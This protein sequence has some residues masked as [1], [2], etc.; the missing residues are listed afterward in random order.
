MVLADFMHAAPID[1]GA[2]VAPSISS[3]ALRVCRD[4]STAHRRGFSL[5]RRK[6]NIIFCRKGFSAG[7]ALRFP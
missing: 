6:R 1:A 2:E 7:R 5:A 3:F 4:E